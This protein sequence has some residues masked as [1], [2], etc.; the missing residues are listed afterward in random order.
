MS[1]GLI[2]KL[3]ILLVGILLVL[4][5]ILY[6]IKQNPKPQPQ[7]KGNSPSDLASVLTA[8]LQQQ[9]RYF[10]RCWLRNS[11]ATALEDE[12]KSGQLTWQ[13]FL[14][15]E[16]SGKVK[17]FSLLNKSMFSAETEKCLREISYRLKFPSFEGDDIA[18][19]VP[20]VVSNSTDNH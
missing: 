9:R 2:R 7:I 13:I 16:S 11:A 1:K 17:N 19:S 18:I 20:I 12:N 3:L 4:I 6:Q 8:S 14:T 5:G 10:Q 15:I